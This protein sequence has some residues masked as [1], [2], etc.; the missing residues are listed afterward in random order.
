[1]TLQIPMDNG[2]GAIM[3]VH[4]A[5]GSINTHLF[6][7]SPNAIVKTDNNKH[8]MEMEMEMGMGMGMGMGIPVQTLGWIVQNLIQTPPWHILGANAYIWQYR[9]RA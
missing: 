3:Q 9:A 1:M 7:Q 6:Y 4:T 2:G 5:F 8:G